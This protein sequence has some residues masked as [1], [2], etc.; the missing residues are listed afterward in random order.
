MKKKKLTPADYDRWETP[1]GV[2]FAIEDPIE[3]P[4]EEPTGKSVAK[5]YNDVRKFN[6]FHDA[7][8]RFSNAQGFSSYSANPKT[9]AGALA[10][11][12][13]FAG[14]HGRTMNMHRE[15]KG[16]SITQNANWLRTGK[17]P[18]VPAAISRAKYQQRQAAKR[19]AAQM[20]QQGQTNQPAA[21]TQQQAAPKAQAA[22]KQRTTPKAQAQQQAQTSSTKHQMAKGKDIS[23]SFSVNNSSKKKAFDQVAEQQGFDKKGRV[24]DQAEFDSIVKQTGVIAYR[25]WNPGK[26]GVTGKNMSASDFKDMFMHADSI[27]AAG[28]GGRLYGGGTYIAANRS[29]VPGKAPTAK[30]ASDAKTNSQAYGMRG[31]RATATITLDPSAKVADYSKLNR[32]FYSLPAGERSRFGNDVG[33]YAAAQ[34]YDAMRARNAGRNCDYITIFNRTKAVILND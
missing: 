6:P 16:E 23:R 18:S 2:I 13:S 22:P 17:K 1:P 28:S 30:Q 14:G 31:T 10:I 29:P 26:D 25:T 9:K 7:R 21:Q 20:L 32:A 5:S 19:Q 11:Q 12:R 4:E 8:G 33:A 3:E 27:Q 15:S 34:G 24:V